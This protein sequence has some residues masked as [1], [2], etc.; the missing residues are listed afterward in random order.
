M[1]TRLKE[2]NFRKNT[3]RMEREAVVLNGTS[4]E[5]L[6]QIMGGRKIT[7][8]KLDRWQKMMKSGLNHSSVPD[9]LT[10]VVQPRARDD[11]GNVQMELDSTSGSSSDSYSEA[12]HLTQVTE[13]SDSLAAH[14]AN[15]TK[16]DRDLELETE[17]MN[18]DAWPF[19]SAA[20]DIVGSP[21]LSRLFAALSLQ[22][23]TDIDPLSIPEPA[24]TTF[25]DSVDYLSQSDLMDLHKTKNADHD[26]NNGN[27]VVGYESYNTTPRFPFA[28]RSPQ[29]QSP[30]KFPQYDV[31][32][33][34]GVVINPSPFNEIYVFPSL[35]AKSTK[36]FRGHRTQMAQNRSIEAESSKMLAKL[37]P[38]LYEHHPRI[39]AAM[40][41]LAGAC[42]NQAKY[43]Q[44][45]KWYRELVSI[46]KR[47][48][49]IDAIRTLQ[50]QID[51]ADSLVNLN[52]ISEANE[53]L[54]SIEKTIA[55]RF[56]PSH[57]LILEFLN[58]KLWV[59]RA[60]GDTQGDEKCGRELLQI[61]LG[62]FGPRHTETLSAMRILSY[63]LT[64]KG[65]AEESEQLLRKRMQLCNELRDVDDEVM[66]GGIWSLA[67]VLNLNN[68]KMESVRLSRSALD[69][70][71]VLLGVD[72]PTTI[73]CSRQ[74]AV[75]LRG[76]GNLRE[77][78]QILEEAVRTQSTI[79]GDNHF[80]TLV[81]IHELGWT[82][83]FDGRYGEAMPCFREAFLDSHSI[84]AEAQRA[85]NTCFGLG[86]CLER[87]G[88]YE[89]ARELYICFIEQVRFTKGHDHPHIAE[90]REWISG[91]PC[92]FNAPQRDG[93][94]FLVSTRIGCA[95]R[96]AT[97]PRSP[98]VLTNTGLSATNYTLVH[99]ASSILPS[100]KN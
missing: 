27:E 24:F 96:E 93:E 44:A 46:G 10:G 72:H 85:K 8:I 38:L 54:Q 99:H 17:A 71:Q 26:E 70:A 14:L 9:T 15:S 39:L 76:I 48:D 25:P 87:L 84:F 65:S 35:T 37:R 21:K 100:N 1:T 89:G 52:R 43:E 68:Q 30:R 58:T 90:V 61:T 86:S 33:P 64:G 28:Q 20:I 36:D 74:L 60:M 97:I 59:A 80:E 32:F 98:Q 19:A 11:G 18:K 16:S 42:F 66:L 63:P 69:R 75:A 51:L 34:S 56:E 50:A 47:T 78:E 29:G 12:V 23:P 53:I 73:R 5:Q 49:G 62:A 31:W 91:L 77:S 57:R 88:C 7:G 55:S 67:E 82:L 95:L 4:S 41:A 3:T 79:F 94:N 81:S 6:E 45:E 13:S 22:C 40:W 92:P 83:Y 2:W